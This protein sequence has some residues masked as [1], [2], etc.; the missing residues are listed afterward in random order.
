MEKKGNQENHSRRQ[1]LVKQVKLK[2]ILYQEN[3]ESIR[4]QGQRKLPKRLP[5]PERELF[6]LKL[7]GEKK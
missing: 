2:M 3:P 5:I 6:K 4:L 7:M 1:G